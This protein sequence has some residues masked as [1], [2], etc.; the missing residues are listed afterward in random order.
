MTIP[1]PPE[2]RTLPEVL[3]AA[4]DL[5][6]SA[7]L[8]TGSGNSDREN[9][10]FGVCGAIQYVLWP[11]VWETDFPGMVAANNDCNR[12][13]SMG[14]IA[15]ERAIGTVPID[16]VVGLDVYGDFLHLPVEEW[17]KVPGRTKADAV[18]ALRRAAE[19]HDAGPTVIAGRHHELTSYGL[20]NCPFQVRGGCDCG[21]GADH[22]IFE[23]RRVLS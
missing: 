3:Q 10:R 2:T 13:V 14:T 18:G 15:V 11:G 19:L 5:L 4:A 22:D 17:T 21:I 23:P 16:A 6:E 12:L 9:S 8:H 1:S 20:E 7:D